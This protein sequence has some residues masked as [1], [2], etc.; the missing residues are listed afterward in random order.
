MF[1]FPPSPLSQHAFPVTLR[2]HTMSDMVCRLLRAG[3]ACDDVKLS[4]LF[5]ISHVPKLCSVSHLPCAKFIIFIKKN[6]HIITI[7]SFLLLLCINCNVKYYPYNT[8]LIYPRDYPN[9]T[10]IIFFNIIF[11]PVNKSS[12]FIC[13]CVCKTCE[14]HRLGSRVITRCGSQVATK[15]F[16]FCRG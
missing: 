14:L 15:V 8:N 7:I 10:L 12:A 2:G 6:H 5:C 1:L 16:P 13:R 3:K 9:T 11:S 4:I